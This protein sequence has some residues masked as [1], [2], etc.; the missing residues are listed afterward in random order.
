[1]KRAKISLLKRGSYSWNKNYEF[2]YNL[3]LVSKEESL[4]WRCYSHEGIPGFQFNHFFAHRMTLCSPFFHFLPNQSSH[5]ED[6]QVQSS[7]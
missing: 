5:V 2:H 7:R 1:M 3:I 6:D 4:Y